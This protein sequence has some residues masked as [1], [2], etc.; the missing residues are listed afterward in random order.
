[1]VNVKDLNKVLRSEV[2]VSKDRQLRVV[3]LILDFKPLSNAFQDIGHEIRP[4]NPQLRKIDV[5]IPGFLAHEDIV[6]VELPSQ[7]AFPAAIP[8]EDTTS[9]RLSLEEEINQFLLKEEEEVRADPVEI[10]DSKG[11]FDR[12]SATRSP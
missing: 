8:K 3:H 5:S 4:G 10:L 7:R 11:E 1:M 9:S 6:P 2:F 12:S